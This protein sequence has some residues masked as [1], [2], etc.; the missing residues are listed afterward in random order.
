MLWSKASRIECRNLTEG[1]P[2][3]KIV[4]LQIAKISEFDGSGGMFQRLNIKVTLLSIWL[5]A[6][7]GIA[8]AIYNIDNFTKVIQASVASI[9][10][11]Q[12]GLLARS[13]GV[14]RWRDVL[15]GQ[16]VF[17]G[18]TLSTSEAGG[19]KI[20]FDKFR[21]LILGEDSQVQITA[22]ASSR[23]SAF[24]I[25]LVRGSAVP[26]VSDKCRDCPPLILRAGEE[27]YTISAGKKI[28]VFK[29]Q[30]SRQAQAVQ[31]KI[32]P[33]N[34][35]LKS[36]VAV[37]NP[38]LTAVAPPP[39]APPPEVVL[40]PVFLVPLPP[41]PPVPVPPPSAPAAGANFAKGESDVD[42]Q[43]SANGANGLGSDHEPSVATEPG[44]IDPDPLAN[45]VID[46]IPAPMLPP[47]TPP[48]PQLS[49]ARMGL[50]ELGNLGE[51]S[52]KI[53]GAD[54]GAFAAK[55]G[56]RDLGRV[57]EN[58]QHPSNLK[59]VIKE[60]TDVS[61]KAAPKYEG[62]GARKPVDSRPASQRL[63]QAVNQRPETSRVAPLKQMSLPALPPPPPPLPSMKV[64]STPP[65]RGVEYW[66][67]RSLDSP[68]GGVLELPVPDMSQEKADASV[69]LRPFFVLSGN[70]QVEDVFVADPKDS[71]ISVP[72]K[73][74][75]RVGTVELSGGVKRY[76]FKI[77]A[78]VEASR[79]DK[80][81]T[82]SVADTEITLTV[83]TLGEVPDG[84]INLGVSEF[85]P[86]SENPNSIWIAAK[87]E[88]DLFQTGVVIQLMNGSDYGRFTN[89]I[90]GSNFLALDKRHPLSNEGYFVVRED[91]IVAQVSGALL[92]KPLII[93]ISS[94]LNGDFVFKGPRTALQ[95]IR[96]FGQNRPGDPMWSLLNKGHVLYIL[97]KGTLYPVS[98]EFLKSSAEV[99]AFIGNQAQAIFVGKVEIVSHK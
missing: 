37:I 4:L 2:K 46:K 56:G 19:A 77:R 21:A 31:A 34:A 3:Q 8:S 30:G 44:E 45:L 7:V 89:L 28:A 99:A 76:H 71:V 23:G 95:N 26:Q 41:A 13:E 81:R 36:V 32:I 15:K 53:E 79:G 72:L 20:R 14:I 70:G 90:R 49:N 87:R 18:D 98:R 63:A 52:L 67:M 74:I 66:T 92:T 65:P 82:K 33:A 58:P 94:L 64:E 91:Q 17:D 62:L 59:T 1:P 84:P 39:P 78:G 73:T 93:K 43:R 88:I 27:S 60:K 11:L 29:P 69:T 96:E 9:E 25:R 10:D 97:K 83:V 35:D 55:T 80:Q 38:T 24:I 47:P 86:K 61:P 50:T 5:S 48:A 68:Q 42:S 12:G 22:I 51:G 16:G 85:V 57:T 75:K 6:V 40:A 54:L